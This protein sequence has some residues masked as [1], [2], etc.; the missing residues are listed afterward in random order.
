MTTRLNKKNI[1][2]YVGSSRK[3]PIE[4][5]IH[6]CYFCEIPCSNY[7][8]VCNAHVYTCRKCVRNIC[9][10]KE[11]WFQRLNQG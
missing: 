9:V 11:L 7:V 1:R 4:G 2:M 10:E 6:A 3:F 5:W 8:Q